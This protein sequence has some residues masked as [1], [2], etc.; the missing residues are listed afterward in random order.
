MMNKIKS[1]LVN[2]I[3]LL[4]FII[5]IIL[6][7]WQIDRKEQKNQLF[8]KLERVNLSEEDFQNIDINQTNINEWLYRK[9][10][11][12]GN[13][14]FEKE[15]YIFTHLSDPRGKYGGAGYWVL[16]PFITSNGEFIVINR[17]FVPQNI[18]QNFKLTNFNKKEKGP[19]IGYIKNFEERNIFT[20]KTDFQNKILYSIIKDDI[21]QIFN[22]NRIE[23]Y[24]VDLVTSNQLIPQ[25][26]E[27]R[28]EFPDN[29]LSYAITWYGLATSLLF[30][31][32]YSRIKRRKK[33][34]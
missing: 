22:M 12:T 24:Y 17:G 28:L 11:L 8:E 5:L 34:H 27:T 31:Y 19:I 30:I 26:N 20:P 1:I 10:A 2:S 29:H 6:G 7:S 33:N 25:S 15:L 4:S 21:K 32:F 16:N 13:Y 23:P 18:I 14:D 3:I 9:V